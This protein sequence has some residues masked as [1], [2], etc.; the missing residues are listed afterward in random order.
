LSPSRGSFKVHSPDSSKRKL[1]FLVV[2][3]IAAVL[4]GLTIFLT[5][6]LLDQSERHVRDIVNTPFKHP[7]GSR[8]KERESEADESVRQQVA[9][10]LDAS[11]VSFEH[12]ELTDQSLKEIARLR[13]V[14][15]LSLA[16]THLSND[17]LKHLTKLPLTGLSLSDTN[18]SDEG[19]VHVSKITTLHYLNLSQTDVTDKAL[20]LFRDMK[21]LNDLQLSGTQITT[22]GLNELVQ[23]HQPLWKLVINETSISNDDLKTIAKLENLSNIF[24]DGTDITGDGLA[25]FKNH[26]HL[27][28]LYLTNCKIKD[29]DIAII[30]RD[31]PQLVVLDLTR[32]QITPACFNDLAKL[33]SLQELL[34]NRVPNISLQQLDA[35]RAKMPNCRIV[36]DIE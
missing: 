21:D 32:T 33:K 13:G 30:A 22:T 11:D 28:K 2:A 36:R 27:T 31:L 20:Q 6:N 9:A 23:Y 29:R 17:G 12:H 1:D 5:I 14:K 18:V 4:V 7:P 3:I 34:L 25:A 10:K 8:D 24:L 19:M 26:K 15:I 16:Y 35:L